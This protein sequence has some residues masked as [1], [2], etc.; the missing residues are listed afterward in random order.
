MEET[1]DFEYEED[2]E[3]DNDN[4]NGEEEDVVVDD[5]DDVYV[6]RFKSGGNPL[7]LTENNASGLHIYQQFE[8]LE[9]EALASRK[10]EAIASTRILLTQEEGGRGKRTKNK[11]NPQGEAALHH[12][13]GRCEQA[14]SVLNEVVR[15]CVELGDYQKA[16]ESYEKI[17][18]LCA[19]DVEA[20]KAGAK[21]YL[22]CGQLEHSMGILEE[23]LKGHPSEADLSV[24]DL[25]LS[26]L[27]Q[28]NA[29]E[30]DLHHIE[31]THM[32]NI[33][34]K[35]L[36]LKLKIK[37]GICYF[38]LGNMEKA[39]RE[40]IIECLHTSLDVN[41]IKTQYEIVFA[42][43]IFL[44][45]VVL[46]AMANKLAYKLLIYLLRI[47]SALIVNGLSTSQNGPVSLKERGQAIKFSNKALHT[48][49]NNIDARLTLESLLLENA[50]EDEATALLSPPKSLNSV[51]QI[52][53]KSNPWWLK[54]K[55]IMMLCHIYRAKGMPEDFID[56]IFPLV[57][58]SLCAEALRQKVKVK[59]RLMQSIL[60][61]RVDVC[62]TKTDSILFPASLVFPIVTLSADSWLLRLI[63]LK[64]SRAKKLLQKKEKLKQE[65]KALADVAGVDWH[66]DDSDV[67]PPQ[68]VH[69]DPPLP[70]LLKDEDHQLSIIDVCKALISPQQYEDASDTNDLSL[71]LA[72]IKLPLEKE[73][74]QALG[75]QMAYDSTDPM[76]GFDSARYILHQHPY[77]LAAW[78]CYYKVISQF[79]VAS[80]HQDA[81]IDYLE[82]YRLLPDDPLVNLCVGTAL[83]NLALGFRLHNKHRD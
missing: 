12:A 68:E 77:S 25:L 69:F 23:Y 75:A 74:L 58:E 2:F 79:T 4:E 56:T 33:S 57:H 64:A 73:Q 35:E 42:C 22:N 48:F 6:F 15:F 39:E 59:K 38:C 43:W 41:F 63:R 18:K 5:E 44:L 20:I 21:L 13:H 37:A 78:N 45:V 52:S 62:N 3:E 1:M 17:Q 7:A 28:N 54:E 83:I 14:I 11:L 19:E 50:R 70:N 66:S 51:D 80:H 30:K 36:P 8:H 27:M 82:A 76:H 26:I 46:E 31:H 61:T 24:L 67:E 71:R 40:Y 60:N 29:H 81:S 49:E 55:L 72:F 34:G 16:A 47:K 10:R 65:K 53:D 32:V 9:Y